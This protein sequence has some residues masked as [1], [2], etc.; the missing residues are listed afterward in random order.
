MNYKTRNNNIEIMQATKVYISSKEWNYFVTLAIPPIATGL[1]NKVSLSY[2][3]ERHHDIGEKLV[4]KWLSVIYRAIYG[5]NWSYKMRCGLAAEFDY[6]CVPER[7]P[8]SYRL[9]YHLFIRVPAE[10]EEAFIQN[11][12]NAWLK[13]VGRDRQHP[14]E[15]WRDL[16]DT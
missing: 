7:T 5:R 12:E 11:S 14:K 9:G 3:V 6:S 8:G 1:P 4:C 16:P 13:V 10:F 2:S 15:H